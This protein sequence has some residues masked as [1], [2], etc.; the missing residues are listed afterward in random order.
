MEEGNFP[1]FVT[2][3]FRKVLKVSC[4]IPFDILQSDELSF[5]LVRVLLTGVFDDKYLRKDVLNS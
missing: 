5:L 3:A 2:K 4:L 1:V